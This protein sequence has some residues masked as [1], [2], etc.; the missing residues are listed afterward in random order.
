M[1]RT[2]ACAADELESPTRPT[3]QLTQD[4][5]LDRFLNLARPVCRDALKFRGDGV[6]LLP[7]GLVKAQQRD[8][9]THHGDDECEEHRL[10]HAGVVCRGRGV[11]SKSGD[12]VTQQTASSPFQTAHLCLRICCCAAAAPAGTRLCNV[13]MS[14]WVSSA[15]NTCRAQAERPAR[16]RL[17]ALLKLSRCRSVT[18][19]AVSWLFVCG[20]EAP[21]T[22][23]CLV[24]NHPTSRCKSPERQC[25]AA[26]PH[27][28]AR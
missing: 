22:T 28:R 25:R 10:V 4:N 20:T 5:V 12:A 15:R 14:M 11:V 3:R 23:P 6:C 16:K 19:T 21:I 1:T 27:R 7:F 26:P 24:S 17:S 18:V 8:A 9:G 13:R 2:K